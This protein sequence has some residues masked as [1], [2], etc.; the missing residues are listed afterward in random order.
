F[1][2]LESRLAPASFTWTGQGPN[3]NWSTG[4]N[5]QGGVAPLG[6][7]GTDDLVFPAG[8]FH[9]LVFS[10]ANGAGYTVSGNDFSLNPATGSISV[11]TQTAVSISNNIA[12]GLNTI[13]IPAGGQLTLSGELT[14]AANAT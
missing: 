10:S 1:E 3:A 11:N 9:S 14:G 6:T 5:W 8:I 12:I 13:S 2:E 4:A 7:S